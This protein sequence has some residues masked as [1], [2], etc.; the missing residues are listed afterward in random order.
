IGMS[1]VGLSM[2]ADTL[3]SQLKRFGFLAPTGLPVPG[4]GKGLIRHPQAWTDVDLAAASFGQGIA[5]T[6][7]QMARAYVALGNK[8]KM[9]TLH[10]LR[11]REPDPSEPQVVDQHVA[12]EVLAMLQGVVEKDGTGTRARIPGMNVG[13]KTG[14]A[15][16]PNAKGGGYGD[17]FVASFVGF[18]PAKQPKYFI[19]A[20]VDEPYP[21]HYGGVVAAPVVQ[22][23]ATKLLAYR[24]ES[25]EEKRMPVVVSVGEPHIREVAA[26]TEA[27]LDQ[28]P[29]GPQRIVPNLCGTSLR[30][31][32]ATLIHQGVVPQ[33]MGE[34]IFVERQVPRAGSSWPANGA[35][36]CQLWL[37]AERSDS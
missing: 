2:G 3:Y 7:L 16:K 33:I 9:K 14:T 21:Q 34:G 12:D 28:T 25:P 11:D 8:G 32:V 1:K 31:A 29:S 5:V 23:V 37:T 19:L 13:G 22:K 35:R 26:G 20:M 17:S 4:E 18:I 36:K 30:R 10:L 27:L 6:P 24:G 15:Q